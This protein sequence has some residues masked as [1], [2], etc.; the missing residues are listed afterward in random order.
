M[1]L[2]VCTIF[3]PSTEL[4]QALLS[5]DDLVKFR[6]RFCE[7]FLQ[8]GE[9]NF[10]GKCQYSHN[11]TWRR[12]SPQKY[13]YEPRLCDNI[14]TYV[15]DSGKKQTMIN[16]HNGKNCK[17]AHSREEVLFHPA[18]YK[19]VMC[20]DPSCMRYYCPFAHSVDELVPN[21]EPIDLIIRL[22]K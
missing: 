18:L 7:R 10:G 8:Y 4:T 14:I 12:R 17:F 11:M 9:C 15:A 19:T 3:S 6:T 13:L 5:H 16:C 20:E 22:L 21:N 1:A 2:P